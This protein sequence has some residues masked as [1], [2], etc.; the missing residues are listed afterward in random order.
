MITLEMVDKLKERANVSYEDAKA[1]LEVTNGDL[2]EAMIYLEKQGK[3]QGPHMRSYNTQTGGVREES[4]EQRSHNNRYIHERRGRARYGS[5]EYW[6]EDDY[7]HRGSAFR[8][9]CRILRR[10]L[11][12]LIRKA[13]ANQF[14]VMTEGRLL[15]SMPVTLLAVAVIFFFWVTIPLLLIGLFSGC[16]YKFRGPDLGRD[17]INRFMDQAADTM[18]GIRRSMMTQEQD[19]DETP[20]Q[21]PEQDQDQDL[22]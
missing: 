18:D 17:A 21:E 19:A 11:R 16:R 12:M 14:V 2:L 3:I 4:E 7:Q 15:M 8:E 13:N 9:Q 1:A 20:D 6:G 10:K 5:R 22:G